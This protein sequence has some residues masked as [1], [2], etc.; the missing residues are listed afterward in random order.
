VQGDFVDLLPGRRLFAPDDDFA[1]VRGGC[2]DIAV[3]GMRPRDTPYRAF[4]SVML[5]THAISHVFA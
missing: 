1:V 2:E 5:S 3:L 4:V